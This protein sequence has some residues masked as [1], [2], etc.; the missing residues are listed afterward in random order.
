M[1][2]CTMYC[3]AIQNTFINWPYPEWDTAFIPGGIGTYHPIRSS[4]GS[5][6]VPRIFASQSP[7]PINC[8]RVTGTDQADNMLDTNIDYRRATVFD[9][10]GGDDV[11]HARY[12]GFPRSMAGK[13]GKRYV[14]SPRTF[15]PGRISIGYG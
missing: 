1:A 9:A 6:L 8:V 15:K 3:D 13:C 14:G 7:P 2:L 11:M 10:G 12:Y 4:T 5:E